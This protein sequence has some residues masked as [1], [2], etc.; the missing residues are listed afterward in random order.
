MQGDFQPTHEV[1]VPKLRLRAAP[2]TGKRCTILRD[3]PFDHDV[4]KL[5]EAGKR[6]GHRWWQVEVQDGLNLLEGF[7]AAGYLQPLSELS[8]GVAPPAGPLEV[9]VDR[10]HR[11]APAASPFIIGGLAEHAGDVLTP[12][13]IVASAQRLCHFLA[14]IAHES[15]HFQTLHEYG[16][17]RYFER[18]DGRADLGNTEPGDGYRYRGRGLIQLTGRANY[19]RF[20]AALD[21]DLEADPELAAEPA[22]ALSLAATYRA[23][24]RL[25]EPADRDDIETIT[26]R[27]NGGTNGLSDRRKLY[28]RARSIWG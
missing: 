21:L 20:G 13:G 27:I 7:V 8:E 26:R 19:R 28:A 14:Q 4:R 1:A 3:L 10:L 23:D 9:T 2:G 12:F 11:L 25:N 22:I 17:R 15:A 6:D 5:A 18:Y 24:R 16:A